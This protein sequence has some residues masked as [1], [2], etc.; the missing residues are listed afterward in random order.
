[1]ELE[2]GWRRASKIVK[3]RKLLL[4]KDM[5]DGLGLLSFEGGRLRGKV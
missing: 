5:L 2:K 3:G 4:S 1:M